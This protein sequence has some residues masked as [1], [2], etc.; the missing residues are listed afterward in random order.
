MVTLSG[1][2]MF[3]LVNV[4]PGKITGRKQK[5]QRTKKGKAKFQNL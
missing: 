3:M 2:E 1:T 5:I 4:D